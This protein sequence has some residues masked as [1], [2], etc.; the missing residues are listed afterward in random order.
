MKTFAYE[1]TWSAVETVKVG[2]IIIDTEPGPGGEYGDLRSYGLFRE[3]TGNF[4][5]GWTAHRLDRACTRCYRDH[6]K[7]RPH[8]HDGE[9]GDGPHLVPTRR[10]TTRPATPAEAPD[11]SRLR[12][13]VEIPAMTAEERN[14]TAAVQYGVRLPAGRVICYGDQQWVADG[15]ALADEEPGAVIVRRSVTIT[16]GE[17]EV[18]NP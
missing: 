15:R 18:T 17:W 10:L 4:E 11:M 2:T 9:H 14:P 13:S 16:Y 1:I 6:R 12:H 5:D 7:V 8:R 3:A